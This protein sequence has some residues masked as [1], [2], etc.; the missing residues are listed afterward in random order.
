MGEQIMRKI[1]CVLTLVLLTVFTLIFINPV[2][3]EDLF[4]LVIDGSPEEVQKAIDEGANINARDKDR[5]TPLMKAAGKN[6]NPEV[7]EV[8][9]NAGANI[10]A[11]N[12]DGLTPLIITAGLNK[13][14]EVI[15]VLLD[16]GANVN[17]RNE[18]GMTPLM[19]A[20]GLNE[21][22]EVI[23][24]LLNNKADASLKDMNGNTAFDYAKDNEHL[25]GT[26]AYW[27]LKALSMIYD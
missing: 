11:R 9:L 4:E 19:I 23:N 12:E 22:S 27:K 15:E 18:N 1:T 5:V 3:A 7:I 26:D 16:A 2:M 10:S 13:N 24:M 20:G 6:K 25:K 17:A 21:N 8:L 14:P